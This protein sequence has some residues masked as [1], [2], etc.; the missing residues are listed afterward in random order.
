[1]PSRESAQAPAPGAAHQGVAGGAR[2]SWPVSSLSGPVGRTPRGRCRA[3]RAPQAGPGL[4]PQKAAVRRCALIAGLILTLLLPLAASCQ[5]RPTPAPTLTP[6]AARVALPPAPTAAPATKAPGP[7]RLVLWH[8]LQDGDACSQALGEM[9]ER[10]HAQYPLITVEPVYVGGYDD[11]YRKGVAA[12]Q[13]GNP[14]DLATAYET[15]VAEFMREG[16]VAPLEPYVNDPEIGLS[17]ADR[18]DIFPGHWQAGLF[19]EFGGRMLSLPFAK[20]AVG[21]YY[22]LTLLKAAGIKEPP[23]SWADFELACKAV[24]KSDVKGL[25]WWERSSTFDGFL[26]SRGAR[27]LNEDQSEAIFNGP[28]GVEAL[29]LLLRLTRAGHAR[30][31]EDGRDARSLFA[32]GKIAF[33]FD[34]TGDLSAYAQAIKQAGARFEWG[35]TMMPQS[36]PARPRAVLHGA[37]LC[38]F[39]TSEARQRAAWQFIRWFTD[40]AQT[41]QWASTSGCMPVR[42]SAITRLAGAGWLAE[43]K[44]E[45]GV[46]S[47]IAPH[48]YPVPN[49]RGAEEIGDHVE[50]AWTAAL[51]GLKTPRQALDEAVVRANQALAAKQ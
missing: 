41:A 19:P 49:V 10:F 32:A 4:H 46:Y 7:V 26:Y 27:P 38:V 2:G 39:K 42:Q 18:A 43:H 20:S 29:E 33:T 12:I 48:G 22:N 23:Q 34:S 47:G 5:P 16:G 24:S 9:C 35:C 50:A 44:L 1:M 13:A 15:H 21:L 40:T 31:L 37:S 8:T 25:A 6:A 11:L 3:A 45:A 28:E 30:G 36:D 51:S 14:P 17:A